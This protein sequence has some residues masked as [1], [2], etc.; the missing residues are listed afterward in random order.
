MV[1]AFTSYDWFLAEQ[2]LTDLHKFFKMI[3]QKTLEF[4]QVGPVSLSCSITL[5]DSSGLCR[6]T[7]VPDSKVSEVIA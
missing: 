3:I 1:V 5:K 4:A 2:C 6:M 7:G